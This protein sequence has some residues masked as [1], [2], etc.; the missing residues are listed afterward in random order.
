MKLAK[1]EIKSLRSRRLCVLGVF[2]GL[3]RHTQQT[4]E[5]SVFKGAKEKRRGRRDAENAES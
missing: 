5:L 2:V 4:R 1:M 3:I